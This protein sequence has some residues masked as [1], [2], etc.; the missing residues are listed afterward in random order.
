MLCY[1]DSVCCQL[2]ASCQLQGVASC[3]CQLPATY[4]PPSPHCHHHTP[5]SQGSHRHPSPPSSTAA[6]QNPHPPRM[7]QHVLSRTEPN[8]S[9]WP[10]P[11]LRTQTPRTQPRRIYVILPTRLTR[12]PLPTLLPAPTNL[13]YITAQQQSP[14]AFPSCPLRSFTIY[15]TPALSTTATTTKVTT[16]YIARRY[17]QPSNNT[18]A[19]VCRLI[20]HSPAV[21][22][23]SS[24]YILRPSIYTRAPFIASTSTLA[25]NSTHHIHGTRCTFSA[26]SARG[27][28]RP[29]SPAT[30][31]SARSP[32]PAA[33]SLPVAPSPRPLPHRPPAGPATAAPTATPATT[34]S[35]YIPSSSRLPACTTAPTLSR[36]SARTTRRRERFTTTAARAA[37]SGPAMA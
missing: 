15:T 14:E 10:P 2:R 4:T 13:Y 5:P 37:T 20:R 19:L 12:R 34:L 23:S 24:V 30:C 7:P 11:T 9:A 3:Q 22:Q 29:T 28:S 17:S 33:P 36:P 31:T 6:R 27:A 25:S 8:H 35:A 16:T 32:S 18:V 21:H 1:R 26:A